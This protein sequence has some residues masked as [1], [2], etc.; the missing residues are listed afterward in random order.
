MV[1]GKDGTSEMKGGGDKGGRKGDSAAAG[2][3]GS[4][5]E[6]K[7]TPY[8]ELEKSGNVSV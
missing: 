8:S 6:A 2:N 1:T 4:S 3:E 7:S 5:E